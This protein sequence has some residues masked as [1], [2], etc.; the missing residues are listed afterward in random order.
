MDNT[1]TVERTSSPQWPRYY[2]SKDGRLWDGEEWGIEC[3][4]PLIYADMKLAY[5]DCCKLRA[6]AG[7][8]RE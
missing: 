8:E 3:Q 7:G 1:I 6:E 4:R 5:A 2:L